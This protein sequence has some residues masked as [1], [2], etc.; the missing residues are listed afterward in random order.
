MSASCGVPRKSRAGKTAGV[1]G[2][3]VLGQAG[4]RIRRRARATA[5]C[6]AGAGCARLESHRTDV[7]RRSLGRLFVSGAVRRGICKP[8]GCGESRR[9]LAAEECLY[10]GG[11][12]LRSAGKQAAAIGN[13]KLP[14]IL[15]TRDRDFAAQGS[16]CPGEDRVGRLS[17]NTETSWS[18]S[19]AGGVSIHARCGS[20]SSGS[21]DAAVWRLSSEPAEYADGTA[22]SGD[23]RE[24]AGARTAIS[25][26][27]AKT[28][29]KAHGEHRAHREEEEDVNAGT[30]PALSC[31]EKKCL[32]WM[33]ALAARA[34]R[35]SRGAAGFAAAALYAQLIQG[36]SR[37][38][39][40]PAFG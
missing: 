15:G 25:R 19:G 31:A 2:L 39:K 38:L 34:D 29:H 16:A 4:S 10:H 3:Y 27:R 11:G 40:P 5:H 22:D 9:R 37:C 35:H 20:G 28:Q 8:A 32:D 13:P 6:G 24:G 36:H 12:A 30:R 1:S 33:A 7:Y 17:G 14:R 21:R 26:A 18:D 23:V